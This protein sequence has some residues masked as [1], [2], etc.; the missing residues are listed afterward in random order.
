MIE[1][2]KRKKI[3]KSLEVLTTLQSSIQVIKALKPII[4][5]SAYSL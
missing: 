5:L 1:I 3:K 4:N 2:R